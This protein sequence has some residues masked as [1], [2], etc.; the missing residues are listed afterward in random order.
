MSV[1][2]AT[3]EAE[4]GESVERWGGERNLQCA[5]ALQP[6]QKKKKKFL[7]HAKEKIISLLCVVIKP[8]LLVEESGII[9]GLE[10][11]SKKC[12][13]LTCWNANC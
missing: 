10:D 1:I 9:F 6:R 2:P 4:T 8:S 3:Q 5:I 12:C 11:S 13:A 7:L